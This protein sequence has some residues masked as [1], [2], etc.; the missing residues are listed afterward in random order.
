MKNVLNSDHLSKDNNQCDETSPKKCYKLMSVDEI[1]N[2]K[3]GEFSGLIP[4]I[5]KFLDSVDVDFDTRCTISHYLKFMSKKASGEYL[6]TAQWM[7]GFVM[8]HADYKQDSVV[9][10]S[11]AYDLVKL[12]HEISNKGRP[13]PEL[14]GK[15]ETRT[16]LKGPD[17]T[18]NG[19]KMNGKPN[20]VVA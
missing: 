12:C 11:I 3:D 17:C 1:I 18:M 15:P 13:C 20:G 5:N 6:T 9:T 16:S 14:F 10:E 4:L 19:D 2:G 7:R 8:N